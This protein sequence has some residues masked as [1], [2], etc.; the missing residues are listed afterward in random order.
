[1]NYIQFR[2]QHRLFIL[3]AS[4]LCS[5]NRNRA[6][7]AAAAAAIIIIIITIDNSIAF[8]QRR[9]T[10]AVSRDLIPCRHK[11]L[12]LVDALLPFPLKVFVLEVLELFGREADMAAHEI[13]ELSSARIVR[14]LR[15]AHVVQDVE[16]QIL[17]HVLLLDELCLDLGQRRE[18]DRSSG[19]RIELQKVSDLLPELLSLF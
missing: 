13:D 10:V 15:E 11:L 8:L 1:M 16:Q 9:G 18:H 6:A 19:S 2:K 7:A 5:R 4:L 12:V 14:E 3:S 17:A